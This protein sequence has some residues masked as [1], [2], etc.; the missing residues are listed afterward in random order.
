MNVKF[1]A[2]EDFGDDLQFY[3]LGIK[4]YNGFIYPDNYERSLVISP[5]ISSN[6]LSRFK[7][8]KN[9]LLYVDFVGL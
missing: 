3:P 1:K 5:F 2:P 8:N 9:T 6:L 4:N 7:G